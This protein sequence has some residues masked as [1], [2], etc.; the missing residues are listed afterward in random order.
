MCRSHLQQPIVPLPLSAG[1]LG[2]G[3]LSGDVDYPVIMAGGPAFRSITSG[4]SHTC[5][6]DSQGRAWCWGVSQ[7][8]ESGGILPYLSMCI[9]IC[10]GFTNTR[11][12]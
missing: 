5:A 3:A 9:C 6:L 2:I 11:S 7:N 10:W 8:L 4:V 12:P 1:R